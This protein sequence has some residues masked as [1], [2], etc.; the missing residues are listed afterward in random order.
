MQTQNQKENCFDACNCNCGNNTE[1]EASIQAR[2]D[3][4]MDIV[5]SLEG[6]DKQLEFLQTCRSGV[7]FIHL[8]RNPK[9]LKWA[10]ENIKL[11]PDKK[12][13][14]ERLMDVILDLSSYEEQE[15]AIKVYDI[16]RGSPALRAALNKE[17][18]FLKWSREHQIAR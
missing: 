9:Y 10:E 4:L 15:A 6:F 5:C 7:Q 16:M 3:I 11:L 8:N 12:G 14:A 18:R 13:E 1:S 2:N 17:P